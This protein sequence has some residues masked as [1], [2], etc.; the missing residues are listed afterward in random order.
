MRRVVVTGLG[1]L[2]PLGIG[3]DTNWNRLVSGLVGINKI[4]DFDVSDLP[5]KIAGQ[6]PNKTND[7]EGGL[8]IDDWLDHR[9]YK[10]IDRFIA[11]GLISA[12]QAVEDSAWKPKNET[13]KNDNFN[14]NG[15]INFKPLH[16]VLDLDIKNINMHNLESLL[17]SIYQNN[18]LRFQN[19]SGIVNLN[20][21]NFDHKVIKKASLKLKFENS[22]LFADKKILFLD[23]F[24]IL[25]ISDY[26][27]LE[28]IDQILQM[29]IKINILNKEKFNRFLFNF[30]KNKIMFDNLYFTYQ[31]NANNG[32][33]F[34]SQISNTNYLNSSEF[35]SFKNLQ[36]L[37]NLLKDEKIFILD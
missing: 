27:Y 28:N 12:A 5:C 15:S 4:D 16:F 13:Q 32:N 24:A 2:T 21:V 6:I 26:K 10:R 3:I 7:P 9:E 36:Q 20:L 35:Y 34:I 25:E 23:D 19:L 37:K 33:S 1:L 29:T 14:L 18:N 11:Y 17:Y 31:Y 22:K 8:N 30:K